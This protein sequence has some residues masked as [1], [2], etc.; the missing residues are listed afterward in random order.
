L[1]VIGLGLGSR[2]YPDRL[3]WLV[4]EF[5]GD[6]LWALA[7]FLGLLVIWP[8]LSRW[9]AAGL[10]LLISWLVEFSQLYHAPWL[11]AIR[12]TRL[13]GLVLGFGF[14][15]SDLLCYTVGVALGVLTDIALSRFARSS[16][17]D[18]ARS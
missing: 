11:D 12:S 8:T 16:A 14:L 13:G 5:A 9:K 7:A 1:I 3:P 2:R 15:G 17:P 10:A 6:T 18:H 4:R